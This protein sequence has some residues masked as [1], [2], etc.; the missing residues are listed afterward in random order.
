MIFTILIS[1]VFIAELIIAI[2]ILLTLKRWSKS[3]R[4]IN[5]TLY[6]LK[7]SIREICELSRKISAQLVEFAEDFVDKIKRQQE[8]VIF[9]N[10]SRII[11]GTFLFRKLKKSKVLKLIGKGLSLLEIVV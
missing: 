11:L 5:K 6:Y 10:V 3:L 1:I 8:E 9:R 4:N 2:T 7:P